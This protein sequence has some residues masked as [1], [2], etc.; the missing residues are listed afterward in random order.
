M[1]KNFDT[2]TEHKSFDEAMNAVDKRLGGYAGQYAPK[3]WI[4]DAELVKHYN[5]PYPIGQLTPMG[6]GPSTPKEATV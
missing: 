1:I 2:D 3:R 6:F 4:K 5:G